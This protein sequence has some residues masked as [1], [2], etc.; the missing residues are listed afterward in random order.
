MR[1]SERL[2][3]RIRNLPTRIRGLRAELYTALGIGNCSELRMRKL[4]IEKLR[5]LARN[6]G[7]FGIAQLAAN[8]QLLQKSYAIQPDESLYEHINRL[9][10]R[11][12]ERCTGIATLEPAFVDYGV[13]SRRVVTTAG[14]QFLVDCFQGTAE[15]ETINFHDSGTGTTAEAVGDTGLVTKVETGRQT[16]TQSEPAANQYRST[17]TITYTGSHAITEHGIFSASSGGTLWDRSVF[18]AVNVIATESI[19]FQYTLTV[20]SGG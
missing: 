10:S 18:S 2:K 3:F 11:I 17:A 5:N 13:V 7:Y 14:V 19:Q 12:W 8:L 1:A 15:P 6:H 4:D 20:N 16:G 9:T